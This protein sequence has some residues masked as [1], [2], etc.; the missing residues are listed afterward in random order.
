MS[1]IDVMNEDMD[2]VEHGLGM[3][4]AE[5]NEIYDRMVL[6]DKDLSER[7]A[8]AAAGRVPVF[9]GAELLDLRQKNSPAYRYLIDGIKAYEDAR[10]I[11]ALD[12]AIKRSQKIAE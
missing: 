7:V 10:C 1:L 12:V 6:Q 3:T 8:A 2:E 11:A 9:T 4:V 5:A